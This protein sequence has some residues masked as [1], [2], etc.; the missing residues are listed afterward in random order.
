MSE[1][2]ELFVLPFDH[3]GSFQEKMFGILGKPTPEEAE[4]ISFFKGIVYEGFKMAIENGAVPKEIGAILVDEE[5]GDAI[6][7]DAKQNGYRICICTEKSGQAEFDFE[8]GENFKEHIEKYDPEFVK[9]LVRYNPD[10]DQELNLRQTEKLKFLSDY[11]REKGYK[12]MIEPLVPPTEKQLEI[13]EGDKE[14]YDTEMR[15]KLMELMIE[16]LQDGGV[17]PA[18]WKIEGL[19][20]RE[21]YELLVEQVRAQGRDSD[22]IILGR[23]ANDEQ[24]E[25]WL[26][27]GAGV[28]GVIGFAIGRTIFWDSL[29]A[30]KAGEIT[31]EEASRKIA[32][33]FEYFYKVFKGK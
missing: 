9:V 25:K 32:G 12:M 26:V 1:K 27:A 2:N 3:R 5:F 19:E 23:H 13:V 29:L 22:I 30:Y 7:K 16:E 17:E 33:R 4:R 31:A 10:G 18:V 20:E 15:P 11:C 8:F 28:E 6:L 14:I 21:D 24:L